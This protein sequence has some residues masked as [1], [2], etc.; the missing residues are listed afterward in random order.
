M[1]KSNAISIPYIEKKV[2]VGVCGSINCSKGADRD[3]SGHIQE[4]IYE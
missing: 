2:V 3:F 1:L 4:R